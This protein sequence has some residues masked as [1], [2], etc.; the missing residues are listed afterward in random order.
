MPTKSVCVCV[1][2]PPSK[3]HTQNSPAFVAKTYNFSLSRFSY[4]LSLSLSFSYILC[5]CWPPT[6]FL[7]AVCVCVRSASTTFSA[8]DKK[9][10]KNF[11]IFASKNLIA[12]QKS[13]ALCVMHA[14]DSQLT[15]VEL[16]APSGGQLKRLL[17]QQA[18]I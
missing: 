1:K 8:G 11:I 7:Q 14:L 4:C 9:S 17:F 2:K 18:P 15:C 12:Q 13:A 5:V 3:P 16:R 6:G 10:G